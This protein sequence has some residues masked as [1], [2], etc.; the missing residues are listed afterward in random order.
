LFLYHNSWLF[1]KWDIRRVALAGRIDLLSRYLDRILE[2]AVTKVREQRNVTGNDVTQYVMIIDGNG[3][4]LRQHACV[5][6]KS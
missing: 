3:Y 6:C 5:S 1:G 2:E 4:N